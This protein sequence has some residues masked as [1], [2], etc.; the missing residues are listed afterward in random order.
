MHLSIFP[1]IGLCKQEMSFILLRNLPS[2]KTQAPSRAPPNGHLIYSKRLLHQIPRRKVISGWHGVD[3]LAEDQIHQ[4][5]HPDGVA[6]LIHTESST[7]GMQML[8]AKRVDDNTLSEAPKAASTAQLQCPAGTTPDNRLTHYRRK[9]LLISTSV[10]GPLLMVI[11]S[12]LQHLQLQQV[13]G[14]TADSATA[15]ILSKLSSEG[16]R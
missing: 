12:Q 2:T 8:L 4:S 3:L 9:R 14:P 10:S 1:P 13:I 7:M 16:A 6:P 11:F 15:S 5:Y